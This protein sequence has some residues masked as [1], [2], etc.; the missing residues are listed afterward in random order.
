MSE[1]GGLQSKAEEGGE[2]EAV[3]IREIEDREGL[4]A[5]RVK[6]QNRIDNR[7]NKVQETR[8]AY[9]ELVNCDI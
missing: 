2:L 8:Y 6:R 1:S 7:T 3:L 5:I 4:R 9:G